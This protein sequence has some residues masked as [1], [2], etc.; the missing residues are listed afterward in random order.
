[1]SEKLDE[2]LLLYVGDNVGAGCDCLACE[3]N[4]QVI[5]DAVSEQNRKLIE[6]LE[7]VLDAG[8]DISAWSQFEEAK[9]KAQAVLAEVK[10]K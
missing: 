3:A 10:G 4:R 5:R 8:D 9:S 1:M 6:A 2:L 7:S